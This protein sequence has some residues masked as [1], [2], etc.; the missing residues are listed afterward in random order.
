M[1]H[2]YNAS[3]FGLLAVLVRCDLSKDVHPARQ[4]RMSDPNVKIDLTET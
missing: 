1:W 3:P 4:R 2:F